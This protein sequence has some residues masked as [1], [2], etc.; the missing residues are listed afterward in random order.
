MTF[1]L[2]GDLSQKIN[3]QIEA[4]MSFLFSEKLLCFFF[5]HILLSF[6]LQ[7][8]SLNP[9]QKLSRKEE[10]KKNGGRL[11]RISELWSHG[12]GAE[13]TQQGAMGEQ[14]RWR[15][16]RRWRVG[17]AD[18][19]G[20]DGVGDPQQRGDSEGPW[21]ADWLCRTGHLDCP[22]GPIRLR[23]VDPAGCTFEPARRQRLPF[24]LDPTQRPQ[25]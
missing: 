4:L 19:E 7:E 21:G 3:K 13:S 25:G 14:G 18:V 6:S 11:K 8:R 12:C 22:H 15:G 17:Q 23:Q 16:A 1:A 24:W 9:K 10:E 2:V 5:S 20:P